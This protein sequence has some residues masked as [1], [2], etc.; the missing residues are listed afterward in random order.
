MEVDPVEQRTR[1][2]RLI[3]GGAARRPRAGERRIAEMAAAARVHRRDQLDPRRKGDMGVGP[4]DADRSGLERLAQRIEGGALEFGQLVEEQHSEMGEADLARPDLEPAADQRDHRGAVVRRPVGSGADQPAAGKG[5]GDA[6]DHRHLQRLG[7]SQL[8]QYA[9]QAGG[10]Q[11]LARAGR[12]DHQ[13]IV[14][15]GRRDLER[16]LGRLLPFHLGEVG[17]EARRLRLARGRRREHRAAA[18]MVEQGDEVGRRDDLDVAGPGRLRP[19]GGGADEAE[20]SRRGVH[21][22]QQHSGRRRDPA[23]E[24]ELADGD[25]AGQRLRIDRPERRQHPE[26]DRQVVMRPLL[27]QIRRRQVDR[28]PL[29]RKR[30]PDRGEGG[31]DPLAALGHGLVRQADDEEFRQA[32]RDLHLHLD[33]PSLEPQ[34]RHRGDMSDHEVQ[35]LP[36]AFSGDR[37][38]GVNAFGERTLRRI[39]LLGEII[40]SRFDRRRTKRLARLTQLSHIGPMGKIDW[41]HLTNYPAVRSAL[42]VLG[43]ILIGL[44]PVVGPIPGPGGLVVFAAGLTLVLKYSAWAKRYY[45]RFKRRHPKKGDWADWGL[46]RASAKRRQELA[47]AQQE[48]TSGADLPNGTG[49]E[50][51][52]RGGAHESSAFMGSQGGPFNFDIRGKSDEAHLPAEQSRAQ[53]PARLPGPDGDRRRPQGPGRAPGAG[54]QDPLRLSSLTRRADFVAANR[55]RRAPM[56]GFVLLVRPRDDGDPSIRLGITV[57]KKIGG[58]VVRN[59][60]KRRFRS[61]A[62]EV[63]PARGIAGADH[64][65]IGR[66]GGLERDFALLRSELESALA[67]LGR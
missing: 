48:L 49:N 41:R 9:R 39:D 28:D 5:A 29:G 4:G 22:R 30:Q 8:G 38:A 67:K 27:G 25:I 1:H 14:A 55:G 26:R 32:G 58:A 59:R 43:F 34:E 11:R 23:V 46:R 17:A 2:A 63:L 61:L 65:L 50:G 21:R 66:Q 42:V 62:R 6:G 19:L 44:T 31:M 12:P 60:M 37:D 64:V 24:P 10:E 7:R 33:R 40:D 57:T 18:E 35:A 13:Q 16:A 47:K 52:S 36:A 20:A 56:P 53:A 15:A 45:V 51:R 54:P 3:I